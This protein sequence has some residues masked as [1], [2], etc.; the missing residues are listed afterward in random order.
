MNL[1]MVGFGGEVGL[2]LE[3]QF[4]REGFEVARS[5]LAQQALDALRSGQVEAMIVRSQLPD[6]TGLDLVRDIRGV[7]DIP[8]VMVGRDEEPVDRILGLELGADDFVG[9]ATIDR[10]LVAR[11]RAILRRTNES[12]D[13]TGRDRVLRNADLVLCRASRQVFLNDQEL[14]LT[15]AEFGLVQKLLEAC[16]EVVSK[17]S[18]ARHA[19]GRR[20]NANDR[21]IDTHISRLRRKLGPAPGGQQRIVAVRGQGYCLPDIERVE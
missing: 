5:D 10:E 1:L 6:A 4:R 14:D 2:R 16:G 12:A 7:S 13:R 3:G 11:L 20:L 19:L 15:S 18:L 9:Q 17:D 8:I 21:S